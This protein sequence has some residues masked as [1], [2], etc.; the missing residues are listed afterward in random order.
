MIIDQHREIIESDLTDAQKIAQLFEVCGHLYTTL[1]KV[2]ESQRD[3]LYLESIC[4]SRM[5][6]GFRLKVDQ[7]CEGYKA[8][9]HRAQGD[10]V[11]TYSATSINLIEAIEKAGM[12]LTLRDALT[13]I[14]KRIEVRKGKP[15]HLN[16]QNIDWS[17]EERDSLCACGHRKLVHVHFNGDLP[18]PD[19]TATYCNF[20]ENIDGETVYCPC[21]MFKAV[22]TEKV[23]RII[24]NR[25]FKVWKREQEDD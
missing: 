21:S 3:L 20:P 12:K 16:G 7:M 9:F 25:E 11:E 6:E 2:Q 1:E 8:T 15:L 10:G 5:F 4:D 22:D 14:K 13:E 18:I 23:A 24:S 17:R 19:G